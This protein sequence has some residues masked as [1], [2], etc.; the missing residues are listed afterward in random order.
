MGGGHVFHPTTA[1]NFTAS[2]ETMTKLALENM[3][4]QW[5]AAPGSMETKE[6]GRYTWQG[7]NQKGMGW[8]QESINQYNELFKETVLNY[9]ESWAI[10]VEMDVVE[11]LKEG[12]YQNASLD[13]IQ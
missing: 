5:H 3:W 6:R 8:L 1:D 2:D 11:L 4:W 13:E 9:K 7:T 12:Q 10:E